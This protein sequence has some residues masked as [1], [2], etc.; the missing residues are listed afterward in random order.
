[1]SLKSNAFFCPTLLNLAKIK[2]QFDHGNPGSAQIPVETQS[3]NQNGVPTT[4][5]ID[6]PLDKKLP[7]IDRDINRTVMATGTPFGF[8]NKLTQTPT[9]DAF[10]EMDNAQLSSLQ[11]M[12][13][14]YKVIE[15]EK[16]TPQC[17]SEKQVEIKFDPS[18]TQHG[19][20]NLKVED[21]LT[22]RNNRNPG[23]GVK[24]F[25]FTYDGYNP[26]A[27]KKSISARLV[28]HA[29]SFNELLLERKNAGSTD[30]Y[31]YIDLVLRTG[32]VNTVRYARTENDVVLENLDKLNFRLKAV[33]GWENP[34]FTNRG[35]FKSDVL[36][37]INNQAVTLNLTPTTHDFAFDDIGRVTMT[38]NYLAYIEDYYDNPTFNIFSSRLV[39]F[40]TL[41]RNL[42]Y[43]TLNKKCLKDELDRRKQ[44]DVEEE[45]IKEEKEKSLRYLMNSLL[46]NRK[47]YSISIEDEEIPIFGNGGPYGRASSLYTKDDLLKKIRRTIRDE[48]DFVDNAATNIELEPPE[49]SDNPPPLQNDVVTQFYKISAIL[50]IIFMII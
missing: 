42:Q 36:S 32:G 37:G 34:M 50:C 11:P 24:S 13:R 41:V 43:Q 31:R 15:N 1:L 4:S 5:S 23:V 45:A 18:A 10:F 44:D 35:I 17:P 2:E 25:N 49:E 7:F 40:N 21:F 28:I 6:Y 9:K 20:G 14:L 29:N 30:M 48:F 39:T 12:M 47:I 19:L 3:F 27:I 22:D 38:I 8:I 33:L 46:S 16:T 26:Y